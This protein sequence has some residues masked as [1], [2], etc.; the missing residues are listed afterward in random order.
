[1]RLKNFFNE[2]PEMP[3]IFLPEVFLTNFPNRLIS[4]H[5]IEYGRVVMLGQFRKVFQNFSYHLLIKLSFILDCFEQTIVH[6]FFARTH[7]VF[8]FHFFPFL[9]SGNQSGQKRDAERLELVQL[10]NVPRESKNW[11]NVVFH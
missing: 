5:F 9:L 2:R 8:D 6:I 10:R 11:V 4:H 1:M 7:Q 3:K